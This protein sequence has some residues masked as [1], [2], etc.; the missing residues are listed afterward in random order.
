MGAQRYGHDRCKRSCTRSRMLASRC[1]DRC[2][3]THCCGKTLWLSVSDRMVQTD[4]TAFF[5]RVDIARGQWDL[6]CHDDMGPAASWYQSLM[7]GQAA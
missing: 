7:V 5:D 1:A 3:Q 2:A 6:Q 4:T